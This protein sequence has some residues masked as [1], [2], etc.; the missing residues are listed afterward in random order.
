MHNKPINGIIY[1]ISL[2]EGKMIDIDIDEFTNCLIEN[3]TGKEV[4]TFF[5]TVKIIKN[6]DDWSFDWNKAIKESYTVQALKVVDSDE[7]QGLIA[8]KVDQSGG[9]Y[10]N[11]VESAIHNRGEN[12]KYS[13]VGAHLFALACKEAKDNKMDYIY[14]DAK[15]N[16][17]DYY[18]EKLGAVQI[19]NSQRMFIDSD[20]FNLLLSIYFKEG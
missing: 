16:L 5:E 17:I 4:N 19:G 2:F 13:G 18:K 8:T 1:I 3:S 9:I 10:V 15:T 20:A 14:F 6:K 7:I 12:R 11:L